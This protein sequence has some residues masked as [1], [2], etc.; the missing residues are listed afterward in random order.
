MPKNTDPVT[1]SIN[2]QTVEKDFE[3]ITPVQPYIFRK[4]SNFQN[5]SF[6]SNLNQENIKKL[7]IYFFY[8][9]ISSQS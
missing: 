4:L 6:Q 1:T 5:S 7:K 2:K 9:K 8:F 3:V